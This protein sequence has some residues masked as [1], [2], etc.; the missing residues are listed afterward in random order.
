MEKEEDK[1]EAE[2]ISFKDIEGELKS[3]NLN[4]PPTETHSFSSEN[5]LQKHQIKQVKE[6]LER[7]QIPANFDLHSNPEIIRHY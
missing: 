4:F 2:K 3:L 1:M 5:S 7:L 6:D